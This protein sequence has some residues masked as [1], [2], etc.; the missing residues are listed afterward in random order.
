MARRRRT[1]WHW[2]PATCCVVLFSAPLAA[3]EIA[4]GLL[5]VADDERYSLRAIEK[6]Y[7]EG[8]NGRSAVAAQLAL[9]DA[10]FILQSG[11]SK[12]R[13]VAVEAPDQ[14]G[15]PAALERLL[16]Q[17]V[18]HIVLELPASGVTRITAAARGKDLL[19]VNAAAP[20]DV[21]RAAECAPNLLHTLPS[22]AMQSD[23]IAQLLAASKWN[24][25]LVLYGPSPQDSLLLAAFTRSARRFGLKPAAQRPFKLSTDPRERELGNVRLLTA[26]VEYDVVVVLD[27]AGEFAR[28]LP[29]RP[30]LPR[31]VVGSSGLTAQAWSAWYERH[32]APQLNRRF[33][34]LSGRTMGSYD[35]ATWM[36]VRALVEVAAR[37]AKADT[38]QQ[39]KALRQGDLTFDGYKGQALSFRAWDGQ[40]RQPLLL[41]HGNGMAGSAPVEGFL[42]PRTT[43]DTLGFDA[44]ET[45]CRTS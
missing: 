2:L 29:Y 39:L 37:D 44:P 3:R 12:S 10:G 8:P 7:P 19:L 34:K 16:K 27:A 31:P 30:V 35:W 36:A 18:R 13:L 14:A 38:A 5:S 25:P 1:G 9:E 43:L 21:L 20:E 45:G 15:L 4:V 28:E 22:Q 26:G 41:S 40:L 32:G 24:R 42:H 23:A 33:A 6:G 11:G 17:G